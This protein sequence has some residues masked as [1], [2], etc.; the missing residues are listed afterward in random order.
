MV[1]RGALTPVDTPE[2]PDGRSLSRVVPMVP[3]GSDTL[4]NTTQELAPPPPAPA[5]SAPALLAGVAPLAAAVDRGRPRDAARS[6]R[7]LWT[8][9][10][11]TAAAM[12]STT[13][14]MTM[15]TTPPV[16]TPLPSLLPVPVV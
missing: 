15:P 4:P 16:L 6:L 13:S 7:R 10:A 1:S 5:S 3:H 11:V 2:P 14:P 12:V 8:T 9:Y